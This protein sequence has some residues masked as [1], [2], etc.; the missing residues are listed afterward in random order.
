MNPFADINQ[1]LE[2]CLEVVK[3][4]ELALLC[5]NDQTPK[6]YLEAVIQNEFALEFVKNQTYKICLEAMRQNLNALE[7]V[8]ESTVV[9]ERV[10]E[11]KNKVEI[12]L[13]TIK[14]SAHALQNVK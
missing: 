11:L 14:Q 13:R 5:V 2:I 1:T 4:N 7:F 10:L 9:L 12:D 8:K 3:Q 6:I